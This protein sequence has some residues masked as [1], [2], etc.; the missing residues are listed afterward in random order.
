[1]SKFTI[2]NLHDHK[3]REDTIRVL[4]KQQWRYVIGNDT[5]KCI[6]SQTIQECERYLKEQSIYNNLTMV[7]DV[8][9]FGSFYMLKPEVKACRRKIYIKS[10]DEIIEQETREYNSELAW[11]EMLSG[12]YHN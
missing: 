9:L 4:H 10:L 5:Y 7:D 1:M 2:T 11:S 6:L 3:R 12:Y 8:H